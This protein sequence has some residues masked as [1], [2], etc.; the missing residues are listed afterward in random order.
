MLLDSCSL[1]Q[2]GHAQIL[3]DPYTVLARSQILKQKAVWP[4]W[5]NQAGLLHTAEKAQQVTLALG[6]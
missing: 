6:L 3:Q 2:C 4:V 1:S 5:L